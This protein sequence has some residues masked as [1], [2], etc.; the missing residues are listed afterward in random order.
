MSY[1]ISEKEFEPVYTADEV[2]KVLGVHVGT[3]Y[4]YVNH[5]G[6]RCSYLY[7]NGRKRKGYFKVNDIYEWAVK[8]PVYSPRFNMTKEELT[9]K[10]KEV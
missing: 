10:L 5:K 1:S 7:E 8:D 9:Q 2:A 4:K 6:L 3:V